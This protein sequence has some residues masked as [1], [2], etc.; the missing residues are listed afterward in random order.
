LR[1]I[2]APLRLFRSVFAALLCATLLAGNSHVAAAADA[3]RPDYVEGEILISFQPDARPEDK[4]AILRDLGARPM[5][6]FR[7]TKAERHKIAKPV[8]DAVA[9]YK[10]HPAVRFIEPNY[11]LR[12]DSVPNDPS[13]PLQWSLQNT[14]QQGGTPGADIH[15]VSAWDQ[16]TGSTSVVIAIIDTGIDMT[17]PDL[18]ANLY[19]NPG[20]VP[21]NG[22]DDDGNGL[23]D[24]VHGFDFANFDGDPTDDNGHGTH[25]AGTIGAVGNNAI[26]VAGVA[27]RVQLLPLKFLDGSGSGTTSDAIDCIEYAVDA[28]ATAINA[29]WGG[30]QEPLSLRLA[31]SGANDAGVLFVTAAGNTSSNNDA[32]PN[33]PSNFDLPNIIA[34]GS[35]ARSDERSGFSNYGAATVDLFAPGT[36]ILST[37][38]GNSY[39]LMSGTSMATPHVVGAIALLKSRFPTMRAPTMKAIALGATDRVASL[40]GLSVTGG[41]LNVARMLEG[42]DSIA[43]APVAD[44]A[45]SLASSDR[46]TARWTATGDD[47]TAGTA[48]LYDLRVS[49]APLNAANFA[50][51]TRVAGVAIPHVSGVREEAAIRGLAPLTDYYVALVVLDE[52]GNA[53]P[54]SNVIRVRTTAPPV[55]AVEPA[56]LAGELRTG[57]RVPLPLDVRNDGAG[58]LDF[59]ARALGSGGGPA[60]PWITIA[61]A[62]GSAAAGA[63]AVETVT[64][65]AAGLRGGDYTALARLST[66]DPGH[67][68]LDVPVTLHVISAPDIDV[69]PVPV[70]FGPVAIGATDTQSL[71]V[72]NTGFADLHVT[73]VFMEGADYSVDD[74]PFDLPPGAATEIYVSVTPSTGGAVLGTLTIE[75][76]DPDEPALRIPVGASGIVPAAIT[77]APNRESASLHT[78]QIAERRFTIG[79]TGGSTLSWTVRVRSAGALAFDSTGAL[80]EAGVTAPAP[81]TGSGIRSAGAVG[82][83]SAEAS[84]TAD[85]SDVRILFDSRRGASSGAWSGFISSLVSRGALFALNTEP[86]TSLVLDEADVYWVSDAS[87]PFTA[88]ER[89]ALAAW[90]RGGGSLLIEGAELSALPD[91][92]AL[93]DSLAVPVSYVPGQGITG[94]TTRLFPYEI[95]RGAMEANL[96]SSTSRLHVEGPD[97][98]VL[99][100]DATGYAAMAASFVGRGRVLAVAGRLFADVSAI[101]PDNR[102]IATQSLDWLGGVAWLAVTPASG[103]TPPGQTSTVTARFD[104]DQLAGSEY[105]AAIVFRSNDPA[106]TDFLVPVDLMLTPAPDVATSPARVDFGSVFLGAAKADSVVVRNVGV[107]PLRVTSVAVNRPEVVAS[108]PSLFLT[109]GASGA[110]LLVYTPAAVGPLAGAE[111]TLG[112]DDPDEPGITVPLAASGSPAPDIDIGPAFVSASLTTG[113]TTT[114]PITIANREGSD[115]EFSIHF[116]EE[117]PATAT[118]ATGGQRAAALPRTWADA[119]AAA[120][121]ASG[122]VKDLI[123]PLQPASVDTLPLVLADARGDGGVVDLLV[124]RASARGGFLNVEMVTA[125]DFAPLN[126]GGYVSLDIDQNPNSGREPSFGNGRQDIGAEYEIGLFSVGYGSVDIF[127]AHTGNYQHSFPVVVEPRAIRFSI[128][129]SW[130]GNDDGL[131]NVSG[132]LGNAIAATDWFPNHGHGTIGGLWIAAT[133]AAGTVAAGAEFPVT[134]TLAA[135]GL[136]GGAYRGSVIVESNDPDEPVLS[137]AAEMTVADGPL[138]QAT[139][140]RV[141]LGQVFLGHSSEGELIVS[142]PGTALLSVSSAAIDPPVSPADF[143]VS[144]SSFTVAPGGTQ[145]V[146]LTFTPRAAGS[147]EGS[148]T[149]THDAPGDPVLV[150]LTGVGLVAPSLQVATTPI[151]ARVPLGERVGTDIQIQNTGGST[152]SFGFEAMSAPAVAVHEALFVDRDAEDPRPGMKALGNGGPD[153]FG[154]RWVDSNQPGGPMF[155]W[156]EISATGTPVPIRQLDQ[157]SGPLPIGFSFPFYGRVFTTFN[158]CTHGWISFTDTTVAFANQPLPTTGAPANLL[159]AYWDDLNFGGVER[160]FYHSDGT[161][162]IVEYSDVSR[163]QRGGPY[164]FQIIL[165]PSGAIVYQYLLMGAPVSSGTIGIQN[166]TKTD[167]LTVVFDEEYLRDGMAIRFS[168]APSW[169]W[170]PARFSSLEPGESQSVPVFLDARGVFAGTYQGSL[171]VSSNDPDRLEAII[172]VTMRATGI[173]RITVAPAELR[174]DTLLVGDT[175]TDSLRITNAGNDSLE[176]AITSGSADFTVA[177]ATSSVRAQEDAVVLVRYQPLGGGDRSASITISSNDPDSPVVTVPITAAAFLPLRDLAADVT[178][179]TIQRGSNGKQIRARVMMPA[180]LDAARVLLPGVRLQGTVPLDLADT[181]LR[182]LNGDGRADLDLAF[183]RGAVDRALPE[184]S[185]VA[186]VITGE[187]PGVAQFAARDTV[188]VTG[189]RF[190][191][192]GIEVDEGAPPAV[193]ALH[194]NAPNPFSAATA[195]RFDL[196]SPGA[197][198]LRVYAADGRLV[199]TLLIAPLPAGRFRGQWD[200][201]DDRNQA[202]PSGV[203]FARM[204]VKGSEPF[205][206]VRRW[207]RVR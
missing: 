36:Q 155:N 95:T 42:V 167:G 67:A 158:V 166:R 14:G 71:L 161:R 127:D 4:Q 57:E 132:V 52:F 138:I 39:G 33:F 47:G 128:P 125:N 118:A 1:F 150:A 26:G 19:T 178:P 133:P 181:R 92:D 3:R 27:W 61:P 183:A 22:Q 193:S 108:P 81:L 62:G 188:R 153:A 5:R 141:D 186:I 9:K 194:A 149:F 21:G 184:G 53:S 6:K 187:V 101:F 152:L 110:I 48:T 66:N 173:P 103:V 16:T 73:R 11:I 60:P 84:Q 121:N 180:D 45:G 136:K 69:F 151:Q 44:L 2:A 140:T 142:N 129:L 145:A 35:S 114:R 91:F 144:P 200:G 116:E 10:N 102:M 130:I 29:S 88:A 207:I 59:T 18:A 182:D 43:P 119:R 168:A 202:T 77:V 159:A 104:G 115:L 201:R 124:F 120:R 90:V 28:G 75:C 179:S 172:P 154:Y 87:S 169:L 164:T 197:A 99:I 56:A 79:N 20:E 111:L 83:S 23:V 49:T 74:T 72:S 34:V 148:L 162:L 174:F 109:P 15:A 13:F 196:A 64:L 157:N 100:E 134:L 126:L 112:T 70:T 143:T 122:R 55:A 54:L 68:T 50:A 176:V 199:R 31:I 12:A 135:L 105:R 137:I 204:E 51:A 175:R 147:R 41:R 86:L 85:L 163:R 25:V 205:R 139:A 63:H 58:V 198:A 80:V 146:H 206:A 46:I 30:P 156:Q 165:Y 185:A 98:A 40:A 189:K 17:H 131:M 106:R 191:A 76:D 192:P 203:Y 170:V 38:R 113:G 82:A 195:F 123:A 24:D 177:P 89:S 107:A 117:S 37:L 94:A 65:S 190:A 32:F 96:P 8:P 171:R 78:G 160:A 93:L 7:R 97:A